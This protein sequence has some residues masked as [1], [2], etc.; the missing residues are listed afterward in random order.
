M[1]LTSPSHDRR[2]RT[3]LL[4]LGLALLLSS[5]A[6]AQS[7][8]ENVIVETYYISN[9]DDATDTNGGG[10]EE[11]SRTYRVYLDLCDSC[12]L[13]SIYGDVN[14]TLR[15]S[16]T[17]FFF[18]HLDRGATYGH[19]IN[20][21]ALDE[22]S[23]PVDS[24][25]SL[26]AGSNQKAGI[27]KADDPDGTILDV[28][29][30]GS[31]GIVG[32]LMQ[33]TDAGAG[34]PLNQQD[35]LVPSPGGSPVPPGFSVTGLLPD[36]TFFKLTQADAFI[37]NDT[38]IACISP[39]VQGPTSDNR[40]LVAQLTT[41][42][43]L[44]FE[45]NVEIE[46]PDGSV[47][48]YVANDSVLLADEAP[49]GLLVYPPQCGCTDPNFLEFDP[50]AGC[51]DGSCSTTIIFGCMDTVACNYDPNA[52]FNISQLCCY[53][54]DSCEGL[55]ITIVCPGV[56]VEEPSGEE[57]IVIYPNP[58][59][60]TLHVRGLNTWNRTGDI[61]LSICDAL[62]R[63]VVRPDAI[64]SSGYE[65]D[66]PVQQLAPGAYCLRISSPEGTLTRSFIRE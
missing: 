12:A 16:S 22:G 21:G 49:N 44:T 60:S 55:D 32:G 11:G 24:W 48:R 47:Q 36:T 15:I 5:S 13:R 50:T 58:A 10:L 4:L 18:N 25:L 7:D 59:T 19:L 45:L 30:G 17:T 56:G 40:V 42:G 26:G 27:L 39:G 65:L 64:S 35:G 1:A 23:A 2:M 52:N 29:D 3:S 14:H 57:A 34:I 37:S 51:D 31:A 20:N 41:T 9:A 43:D 54:P 28:N 6:L 63:F 61:E 46:H 38:R 62:G 66:V 53:G 8:I 33:N